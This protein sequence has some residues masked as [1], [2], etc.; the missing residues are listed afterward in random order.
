[1]PVIIPY[2]AIDPGVLFA[3]TQIQGFDIT[4]DKWYDN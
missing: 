2:E 4:Q 3:P 1:V